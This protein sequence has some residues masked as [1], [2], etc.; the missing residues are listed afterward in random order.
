MQPPPSFDPRG[1]ARVLRVALGLGVAAAVGIVAWLVVSALLR[2]DVGASLYGKGRSYT[3]VFWG[4]FIA[5]VALGLGAVA[6]V[7]R[8]ALR[9]LE[10]GETVY[11]PRNRQGRG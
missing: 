3:P 8:R 1:A 6:L 4:P 10:R 9:R 11:R 7:F 2:P 5:F